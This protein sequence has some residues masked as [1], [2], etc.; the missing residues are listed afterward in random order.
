MRE[1]GDETQLIAAE[2]L[3]EDYQQLGLEEDLLLPSQ[4]EME[5]ASNEELKRDIETYI[6]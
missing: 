5:D 6:A 4:A 2:E 1:L 3:K